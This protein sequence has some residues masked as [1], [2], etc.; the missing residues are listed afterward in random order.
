MEEENEEEFAFRRVRR[1]APSDENTF[2]RSYKEIAI[3]LD[4]KKV[5]S[6]RNSNVSPRLRQ[7][8]DKHLNFL[9]FF[10]IFFPLFLVC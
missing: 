5:R 9:F 8:I 7:M 10:L 6:S 4:N 1:E 3:P 2:F